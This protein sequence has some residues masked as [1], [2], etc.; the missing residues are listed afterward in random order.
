MSFKKYIHFNHIPFILCICWI[1]LKL[2]T[3][4]FLFDM[5]T[6]IYIP[7]YLPLS[8]KF[9]YSRKKNKVKAL[10]YI[11]IHRKAWFIVTARYSHP[12]IQIHIVARTAYLNKFVF[13]REVPMWD[14]N[15]GNAIVWEQ[16]SCIINKTAIPS[17]I[18]IT[19]LLHNTNT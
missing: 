14:I 6:T 3:F 19:I 12:N 18:W 9:Y 8:L 1:R 16:Q 4:N 5:S 2:I 11:H 7:V 17:H 13:I 10:M 15:F